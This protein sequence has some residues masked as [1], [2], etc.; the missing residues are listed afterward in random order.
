MNL[1]AIVLTKNEKRNIVRC[2]K[3][4]KFCD[5]II[6]IDDESSDN[7]VKLT[8][9]HGVRMYKRKL[10][11]DFATQRNY[12][13]SKARGKWALFVDAD[14]VVSKKL[15]IE[16][17]NKINDPLI[18]YVG[19]YIK[20]VDYIFG[21]QVRY[22]DSKSAKLLRLAKVRAGKWKRKVHEYW[23][24]DGKVS[25]LDCFL[26]HYP[27]WSMGEFVKSIE[28][29]SST[30]WKSNSKEGKKSSLVKV[31]AW[32]LGKFVNNYFFR[33]G[34]LD[35]VVGFVTAVM[36]SFHSFLSWSELW[37]YQKKQKSKQA[38]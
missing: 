1:S 14:E 6:I 19:F 7:T 25:V 28:F 20:R 5:E 21:E 2:L 11:S 27:H 9:K 38:N 12:G 8:Q 10:N 37:I 17:I 34:F 30:H 22:G 18:K 29:Y 4:L 32:P 33:L 16:I 15:Q 36:M 23:D 3:S 24:V 13:L 35:G 26:Y 31:V